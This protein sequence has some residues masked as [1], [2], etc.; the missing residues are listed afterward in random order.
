M[1]FRNIICTVAALGI[2]GMSTVSCTGKFDD[3]NTDDNATTKVTPA[4]LATQLILNITNIGGSK[5]SIY[6]S[7]LQKQT[8]WCEGAQEEDQYNRLGRIGFGDYT[9]FTNC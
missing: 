2:I 9:D 7:M 6:N 3:Y 1:K 8:A 5:Y 4:M